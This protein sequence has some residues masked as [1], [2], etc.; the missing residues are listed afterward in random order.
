MN[1]LTCIYNLACALFR[2]IGVTGHALNCHILDGYIFSLTEAA[3]YS[4]P[5]AKMEIF[6]AKKQ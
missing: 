6:I 5:S 2:H 4:I 3:T 1:Y